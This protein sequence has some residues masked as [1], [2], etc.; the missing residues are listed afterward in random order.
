MSTQS[1]LNTNANR[2][3]RKDRGNAIVEFALIAPLL[4]GFLLAV[5]DF[6]IYTYAFIAV[7]NAARVSALRNSGGVQS[8][9]DQAS[10][11]S[12]AIEELRG[13]PNT[14]S[15]STCDGNP[16]SVTSSLLCETSPC[17]STPASADGQPA[18]MVVVTYRMPGV[19]QFPGAGPS[20]LS[21]AAQMRIRSIQ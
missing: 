11:C 17:S 16:I 2:Q 12:M 8:A 14:N 10:A 4:F 20:S 9:S 3:S 7:Q 18:A 1:R 5:V 13:L 6:G 19:F 21:R 15:V